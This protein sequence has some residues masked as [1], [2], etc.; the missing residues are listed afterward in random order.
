MLC[1]TVVSSPM[2]STLETPSLL[3]TDTWHNIPVEDQFLWVQNQFICTSE[4]RGHSFEYHGVHIFEGEH[5][6]FEKGV[7]GAVWETQKASPQ[8]RRALR[9]HL[10]L[11]RT[12]IELL[13][14]MMVIQEQFSRQVDSHQSC[15]K[16]NNKSDMTTVAHPPETP[17][18]TI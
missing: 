10:S 5:R 17:H 4:W 2:T 13:P 12:M 3:Y 16:N 14:Q 15:N 11:L 18:V 9:H 6:W 7:K 1:S 8:H